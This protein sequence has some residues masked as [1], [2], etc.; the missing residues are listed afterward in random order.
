[1]ATSI[2]RRVSGVSERRRYRRGGRRRE[3]RHYNAPRQARVTDASEL[4][5]I[6]G[7]ESEFS[8][9][10]ADFFT[11]EVEATLSALKRLRP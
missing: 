11:R 8:L 10:W 6:F 9:E 3:D 5:N 2:E 1:M 7:F 4:A